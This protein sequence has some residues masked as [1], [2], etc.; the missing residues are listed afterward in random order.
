MNDQPEC[1]C[2]I[3]VFL[4]CRHSG[5]TRVVCGRNPEPSVV[6]VENQSRWIPDRGCAVSGMTAKNFYMML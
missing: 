4:F 3:G 1:T 5:A 2:G 6:A